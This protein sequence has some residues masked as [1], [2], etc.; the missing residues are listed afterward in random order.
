MTLREAA[1]EEAEAKRAWATSAANGCSCCCCCCCSSESWLTSLPATVALT[2]TLISSRNTTVLV[3]VVMTMTMAGEEER[4]SERQELILLY[5][6]LLISHTATLSL[7]SFPDPRSLRVIGCATIG[8]LPRKVFASENS[9][10]DA[11]LTEAR[12]LSLFFTSLLSLSS[13]LLS[14]VCLAC[15]SER[16]RVS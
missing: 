5:C 2:T 9:A 11:R 14:L 7:S 15:C 13:H 16:E 10:H 6:R 3:V 8:R 1:S 4:V 12:S